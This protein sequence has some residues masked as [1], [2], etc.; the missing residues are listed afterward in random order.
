MKDDIRYAFRK[1]IETIKNNMYILWFLIGL[2]TIVVL[3]IVL[4][5]LF[6]ELGLLIS[7][8]SFCL[9]SVLVLVVAVLGLIFYK[10]L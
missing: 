3:P 1:W 9:V 6:D 5:I 2:N 8:M 10:Y 4:I 7:I